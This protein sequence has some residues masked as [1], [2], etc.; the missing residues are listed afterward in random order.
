M[1]V[2]DFDVRRACCV[3]GPLE[4]NPPLHVD[5]DAVLACPVAFQGLEAVA[6]EAPQILK[7]RR[8]IQ[9]FKTLVSLSVKPLKLPDKFA[10]R[11]SFGS[12]VAV[13]QNHAFSIS[14]FMIYVNRKAIQIVAGAYP[15][16]DAS[17][18]SKNAGRATCQSWVWSIIL[19]A[20]SKLVF[21]AADT[22]LSFCPAAWL[23][24]K[25]SS[26]FLFV[27]SAICLNADSSL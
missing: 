13:A 5:A 3:L 1:V 25:L 9:N 27:L 18:T 2:H 8:G 17:R 6:G 16:F 22:A 15:L 26:T 4:A 14:G 7:T 10:A 23:F 12:F 21:N 19:T 11:K 24:A 20:L